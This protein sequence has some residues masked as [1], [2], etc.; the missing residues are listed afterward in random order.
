[1]WNP[2]NCSVCGDCSL[3]SYPVMSQEEI[4]NSVPRERNKKKWG[5]Q[6]KYVKTL[7]T[8]CRRETWENFSQ[9]TAYDPLWSC[10]PFSLGNNQL[11]AEVCHHW[12][13]LAANNFVWVIF[14]LVLPFE[15]WTLQRVIDLQSLLLETE[16][17][18]P[19]TRTVLY[20]FIPFSFKRNIFYL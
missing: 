19:S 15:E 5:K 2:E 10:S 1:M 16:L 18:L 17:T 7:V 8:V 20:T 6:F 9:F 14:L 13:N 4:I 3:T 11:E 12:V